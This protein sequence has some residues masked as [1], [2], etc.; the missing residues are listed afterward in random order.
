MNSKALNFFEQVAKNQSCRLGAEKLSSRN[1]FTDY[2][3]QFILKYAT[4]ESEILDLASGS[5]LIINRLYPHVKKIVAIEKIKEF[6]DFIEVQ[7]NI[8]VINADM[9]EYSPLQKFDLI[10]C[11]GIMQYFN[12]DEAA[13]IYARYSPFLRKG[14]KFIVKNQFGVNEDVIVDT[15]SSELQKEYYSMYRTLEHEKRLLRQCGFTSFEVVDIY[16]PECN[17]WDNTHFYALVASE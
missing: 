9:G 2:D 7:P 1:D 3:A 8:E 6:S 15:F 4:P 14:G 5:G 11:F 16:P 12:E 13:K 10:T 17:R